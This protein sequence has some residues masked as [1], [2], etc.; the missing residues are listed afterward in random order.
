MAC[1]TGKTIV[2]V[3]AAVALAGPSG[4]VLVLVPS[5]GL[6]AQTV[7]A[8]RK[9]ARVALSVL[10]VCSDG[11]DEHSADN[12]PDAVQVRERGLEVTTAV[13]RITAFPAAESA[14]GVLRVVF[15]TYHCAPRLAEAFAADPGLRPFAVGLSVRPKGVILRGV[16]TEAPVA[17]RSGAG[18]SGC[19]VGHTPATGF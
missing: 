15:A 2:G 17:L 19:R 16:R 11:T 5:L 14:G 1:G 13:E 4:P 3:C 12:D 7:R 18:S 8:W 10:A 9:D 6:L